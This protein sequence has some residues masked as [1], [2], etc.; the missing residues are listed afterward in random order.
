ME[1]SRARSPDAIEFARGQRAAANE[2][3]RT[4]WQWVRNRQIC[5]QKFRRE[6]AIPPYTA[7]FCC[8]ELR[9]I[10][11]VNGANHLTEDGQQRDRLRR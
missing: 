9:L 6:Y 3:A 5:D 10:L 8:V 11:E 2:F 4:V 7:D 1:R